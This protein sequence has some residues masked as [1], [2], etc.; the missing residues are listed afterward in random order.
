M[1][2]Q[3]E[4]ERKKKQGNKEKFKE[5]IINT[6]PSASLRTPIPKDF[7]LPFFL[8]EITIT[9]KI[10]NKVRTSFFPL[11]FSLLFLCLICMCPYRLFFKLSYVFALTG[12]F[13]LLCM[14]LPALFEAFFAFFFFL[15]LFF[16]I[17]YLSLK[18]N[19][20]EEKLNK[21][22]RKKNRNFDKLFRIRCSCR[23]LKDLD[24]SLSLLTTNRKG[25]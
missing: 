13:M 21:R 11:L 3:V 6:T 22:T 17:C 5:G 16:E 20:L 25:Y 1:R 24:R 12:Y 15:F 10:C 14:P 9:S 4:E 18:E 8:L 2:G 19:L 23:N 7:N